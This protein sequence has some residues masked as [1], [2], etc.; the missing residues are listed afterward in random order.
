MKKKNYILEKRKIAMDSAGKT[1]KISKF[2]TSEGV[3]F[4]LSRG[5]G[6]RLGRV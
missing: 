5:V 3:F 4:W 2:K 1:G 6:D